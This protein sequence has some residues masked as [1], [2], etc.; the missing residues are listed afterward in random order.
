MSSDVRVA[1]LQVVDQF[2]SYVQS[3]AEKPVNI[4]DW[5]SKATY[6]PIKADLHLY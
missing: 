4:L 3:G 6:V 2:V 1:A 5:T